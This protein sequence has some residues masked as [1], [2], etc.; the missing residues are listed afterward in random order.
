MSDFVESN[1]CSRPRTT[2][3]YRVL[4]TRS[5]VLRIVHCNQSNLGAEGS[6]GEFSVERRTNFALVNTD[7]TTDVVTLVGSIKRRINKNIIR[8]LI[9]P[10]F[11]GLDINAVD[12][13][14]VCIPNERLFVALEEVIE[15]RFDV[16]R[17]NCLEKT[18]TT[19]SPRG[20]SVG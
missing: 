9:R 4:P 17:K 13:E 5:T 8:R 20:L 10:R 12:V 3:E 15:N 7:Q 16:T 1:V 2:S 18:A 11:I 14:V 19:R 6:I